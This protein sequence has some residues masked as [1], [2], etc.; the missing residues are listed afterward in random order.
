MAFDSSINRVDHVQRAA[1][2]AAVVDVPGPDVKGRELRGQSA[3]FHPLDARAVWSWGSAAQIVIVVGHRRRNVVV[4]VDDDCAAMNLERALPERLVTGL[5]SDRQSDQADDKQTEEF[6]ESHEFTFL[7]GHM[8]RYHQ[9]S[10]Q[11]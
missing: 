6:S 5:R 10:C 9:A 1:C 7:R 8:K 2:G 11:S 3:L 4:R